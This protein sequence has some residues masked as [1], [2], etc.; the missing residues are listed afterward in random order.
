MVD[1]TEFTHDTKLSELLTTQSASPQD[2]KILAN[3][4]WSFQLKMCT[5]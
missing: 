4:I 2:R 5:S 3:N 1:I